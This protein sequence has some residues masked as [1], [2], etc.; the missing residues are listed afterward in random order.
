MVL[1]R[2]LASFSSVNA[3]A[4]VTITVQ[5]QELFLGSSAFELGVSAWLPLLLF[6]QGGD[7]LL[8]L[9]RWGGRSVLGGGSGGG[10]GSCGAHLDRDGGGG[11]QDRPGG[12]LSGDGE[13]RLWAARCSG[14]LLLHGLGCGSRTCCL[15]S[16]A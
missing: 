2:A 15:L 12:G 10:S 5:I 13:G 1:E 16:L 8:G 9:R 6:G 11:E 4:T 3:A 7:G 14:D